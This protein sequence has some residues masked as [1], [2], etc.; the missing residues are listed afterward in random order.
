MT[1][2]INVLTWKHIL[3]ADNSSL[4]TL[5]LLK[6]KSFGNCFVECS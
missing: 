3:T 6:V 1:N 2:Q 5:K 4:N